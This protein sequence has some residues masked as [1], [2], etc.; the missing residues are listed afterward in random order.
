MNN[1]SFLETAE[2]L[3]SNSIAEIR[4]RL[5]NILKGLFEI[6]KIVFTSLSKVMY[7]AVLLVI[8]DARTY[9]RKYYADDSFNNN[10]VDENLSKFWETERREVLTPLRI[11]ELK[12]KYQI[13]K[14]IKIS[15]KEA[16]KIFLSS[17]PTIFSA[18][19]V[20]LLCVA[21][22]SFTSVIYYAMYVVHLNDLVTILYFCFL[23]C[24]S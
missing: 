3:E 23:N 9:M 11:W 13:S 15:K 5:Q 22:F 20:T 6:C 24:R 14:S 7:L 1:N 19:L 8:V 17:I 10:F 4:R 16:T 21:D 18:I 2:R 12:K